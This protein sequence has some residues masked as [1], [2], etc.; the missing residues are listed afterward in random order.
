MPTLHGIQAVADLDQ[1]GFRLGR[2]GWRR[3]FEDGCDERRIRL[4][5]RLSLRGSMSRFGDTRPTNIDDP[6]G[7]MTWVHFPLI[8][9]AATPRGR[10]RSDLGHLGGAERGRRRLHSR[11]GL[12]CDACG[13]LISLPVPFEFGEFELDERT[14]ELRRLGLVVP[15]EPKVF[16][17]MLYLV[18]HRDRLVPRGELLSV[19][20]PDVRVNDGALA[21]LAKEARR[22]VGDDG[23]AQ[24]TVETRRGHGYRF[25]ATVR[26]A[27][28]FGRGSSYPP[29]PAFVAEVE[30]PSL[31]PPRSPRGSDQSTVASQR[32][33]QAPA[34]A[35]RWVFPARDPSPWPAVGEVR[36][37]RGGSCEERLDGAQVSREHAALFRDAGLFIIRDLGSRNGTRVNGERIEQRALETHDVVRCGDWVG[38]VVEVQDDVAPCE[39]APGLWGGK[40]LTRALASLPRIAGLGTPTVVQGPPG[41]PKLAVALALHARSGSEADFIVVG[42]AG[43]SPAAAQERLLGAGDDGG[44]IARARGGTL[45]VEDVLGLDWATQV[46]LGQVVGQ[47]SPPGADSTGKTRIVVSVDQPVSTAVERS[48]LHPALGARLLGPTLNVPALRYRVPDIAGLFVRAFTESFG[49]PPAITAAVIERLCLYHWPLNDD[50]LAGAAHHAAVALDG[51]PVLDVEHLPENLWMKPK[52]R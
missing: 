5:P 42:C 18:T 30:G 43:L 50:E 41:T 36:L 27:P 46:V 13:M 11:A 47:L 2:V 49:R 35:I 12:P 24:R 15:T 29:P 22:V 44:L 19:L 48:E 20:W 37:G 45:F 14:R 26:E 9:E 33:A 32:S 1:L 4:D 39:Q 7:R 28:A 8:Q 31:E 16:D 38:V 3:G 21:R 51:G 52:E 10:A 40:A 34:L 25:A 6:C 23:K 17:F